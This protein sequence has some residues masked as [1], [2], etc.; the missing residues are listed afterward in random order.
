MLKNI[1][2][3]IPFCQLTSPPH[4]LPF[5]ERESNMIIEVHVFTVLIQNIYPTFQKQCIFK[6]RL[7]SHAVRINL[8]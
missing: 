3:F 5:L 4:L 1:L 8:A 6:I 7:F 2:T